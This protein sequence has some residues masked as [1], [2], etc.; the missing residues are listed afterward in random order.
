[1]GGGLTPD[2]LQSVAPTEIAVAVLLGSVITGEAWGPTK[3]IL[4]GSGNYRAVTFPE[5]V[6]LQN[7]NP[8][9]SVMWEVW[10]GE[11]R[12]AVLLGK[13]CIRQPNRGLGNTRLSIN[14]PRM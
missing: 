2:C 1:M 5:E 7:Y 8:T 3:S 4:L 9:K 11:R 14:W 6:P 12:G 10:G 13:S